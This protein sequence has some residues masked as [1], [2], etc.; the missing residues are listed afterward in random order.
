MYSRTPTSTCTF[1]PSTSRF[2]KII[3]KM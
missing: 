3:D 1:Q 2:A